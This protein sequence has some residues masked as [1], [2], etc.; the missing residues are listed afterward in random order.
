[1]AVI[2]IVALASTKSWQFHIFTSLYCEAHRQ[3]VLNDTFMFA[4]RQLPVI[5]DST[6]QEASW[7]T[8]N[9]LQ[10]T[11]HLTVNAVIMNF[12]IKQVILTG[13]IMSV[14]CVSFKHENIS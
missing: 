10:N 3:P 4:C 9:A 14:L 8:A 7:P 13:L 2:D 12:Y 5:L 1:M 6:E 11:A